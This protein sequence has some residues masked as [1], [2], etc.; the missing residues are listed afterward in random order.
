MMTHDHPDLAAAVDAFSDDLRKIGLYVRG[1]QPV[2]IPGMPMMVSFDLAIGEIAF[3]ER[4][5]T[6]PEAPQPVDNDTIN[7]FMDLRDEMLQRAA[8][9]LPLFED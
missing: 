2:E 3:A 8:D 7:A 9:G 1:V 5:Q 4:T 6:E